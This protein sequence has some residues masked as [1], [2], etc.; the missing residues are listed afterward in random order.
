MD[1]FVLTVLYIGQSMSSDKSLTENNK[2]LN[3]KNLGW[4]TTQDFFYAFD[5]INQIDK[6]FLVKKK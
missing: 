5:Y 3:I 2:T 6:I 1:M 4:Q